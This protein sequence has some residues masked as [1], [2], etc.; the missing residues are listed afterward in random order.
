MPVTPLTV[1]MGSGEGVSAIASCSPALMST[2]MWVATP[3][4]AMATAMLS[5]SSE[6][7]GAGAGAGASETQPLQRVAVARRCRS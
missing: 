5:R 2:R 1:P 3:C 4:A 6:P 7:T